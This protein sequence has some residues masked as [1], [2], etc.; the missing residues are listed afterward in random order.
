M[1]SG[2]KPCFQEVIP[3]TVK[4]GH[5]KCGQ[6]K[7]WTQITSQIINIDMHKFIISFTIRVMQYKL[8]YI[9]KHWNDV[10]KTHI[11]IHL[12]TNTLK[13]HNNM[14][15]K[16]KI[17]F[18]LQWR[19]NEHDG[20]SNHQPHDCLLKRLFR[21]RSRKTSKLRATGLCVRNSQGT[22]EFPAQKASNVENVSIWWCHLIAPLPMISSRNMSKLN[23]HQTMP[24]CN[25][26]KLCTY[27][28]NVPYIETTLYLSSS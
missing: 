17:L 1:N 15:S 22:G 10:L 6:T 3:K 24:M 2:V 28:G 19:H 7:K 4:W 23:L 12:C 26:V 5:I 16:E 21:H 18:L 9:Y 27:F 13:F 8:W 25:N 20:I 14:S 11:Y